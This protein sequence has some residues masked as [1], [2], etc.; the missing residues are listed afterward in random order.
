M[1]K[2]RI[3][4][5]KEFSKDE[6]AMLKKIVIEAGEVVEN[7]FDRLISQNPILIFYPNMSNI[8]AVGALKIPYNSYKENVFRKSKTDYSNGKF[9]YELGWIVSMK[10]GNGKIMT[11]ILSDYKPFIYA[12]VRVENEKMN[13]ILQSNGFNK[14]GEAYNSDRGSYKLNLYVKEN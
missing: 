12:T 11:K 13:H 1:N 9:E 3:G 7:T 10:P 5:A 14:T 2:Y 6:I 8:E 4:Q